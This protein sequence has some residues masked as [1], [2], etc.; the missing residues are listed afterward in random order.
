[1]G[2]QTT[3]FDEILFIPSDL[4]P[5]LPV[6]NRCRAIGWI[7][8]AVPLA[9][10]SWAGYLAAAHVVRESWRSECSSNLDQLG[11]AMLQYEEA[12]RQFPA[13]AIVGRDKTALLSWRVAILPQLGYRSLYERFHL[14]EPW[15]SPHNLALLAEMPREFGCPG[16]PGRRAGKTG[17][18]VVVG[19]ETDAY[20]INTAFEPTRG[21]D[22]R[23]LTDGTSSTVLVLETDIFVP[24]TKP[25]DLHWAKGEPVPRLFS[26]H[27]GGAHTLLA[28]GSVRFLK[29]TFESAILEGILTINGGEVLGRG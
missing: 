29:A 19:P 10:V 17:Y 1:M 13:P 4:A 21:A 2:T 27:E 22:I 15:D 3:T 20:S 7:L 28:D 25:A 12:H 24:W 6:R 16:G 14:D 18:L 11:L 5:E 23:H 9:L 8:A 26:P